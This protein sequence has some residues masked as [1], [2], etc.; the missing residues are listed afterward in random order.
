[1]TTA[2]EMNN[3]NP[4]LYFMRAIIRMREDDI[5]G[6]QG[7]FNAARSLLPGWITLDYVQGVQEFLNKPGTG[8]AVPYL[9]RVIAAHPEDWSAY[10]WRG[11][12]YYMQ[13]NFAQARLDFD[14]A[15][16]HNPEMNVPHA[17]AAAIALRQGRLADAQA[18]LIQGT[19]FPNFSLTELIILVGVPAAANEPRALIVTV[20][21]ATKLALRQW[22]DV[23]RITEPLV[24]VQAHFDA[25]YF[26]Q[27]IAYCNL[28]QY[29]AAEA[30]YTQG[31][32]LFPDYYLLYMLRAEVRFNQNKLAGFIED[33][34]VVENSPQAATLSP[35]I[36]MAQAGEASCKTLFNVTSN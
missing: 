29:A 17:V 18:L 5:L 32:E 24:S 14:Q 6:S 31:I 23:I 21:A 1:M 22:S 27:G 16:L 9:D 7:D 3:Q 30:A 15:L 8:T 36:E 25:L 34:Q 10:Y 11:S 20:N 2:I 13:E 12:E 19:Q 28:D 35:I 33:I 26:M 4:L